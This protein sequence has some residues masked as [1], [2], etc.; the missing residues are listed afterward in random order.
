MSYDFGPLVYLKSRGMSP[1]DDVYEVRMRGEAC[2]LGPIGADHGP[3][4]TV[5]TDVGT[6]HVC[7]RCS[8]VWLEPARQLPAIRSLLSTHEAK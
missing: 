5:T 4:K 3:T 1:L 8:S 7:E 2:G 6:M